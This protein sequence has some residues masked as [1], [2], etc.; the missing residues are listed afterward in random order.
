ML[1]LLALHG[2]DRRAGVPEPTPRLVARI[3]REDLPGLLGRHPRRPPPSRPCC[4]RSPTASASPG[5]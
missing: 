5:A 4:A 1:T 2:A 3:L